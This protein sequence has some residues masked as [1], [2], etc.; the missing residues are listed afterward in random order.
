VKKSL[1][2]LSSAAV[3]GVYGAGYVRTRAAAEHF[4]DEPVRRHPVAPAPAVHGQVAT[5]A[6]AEQPAN[7]VPAAAPAAAAAAMPAPPVSSTTQPSQ[8][9]VAVSPKSVSAPAVQSTATSTPPAAQ[10]DA[11]APAA[12]THAPVAAA[13]QVAALTAD[14]ALSGLP[15]AALPS[16]TLAAPAA[17]QY[18]D[19]T[20]TGW[21]TCRHGDI[22]AKVVIAG[23]KIASATIAQCLTRYSCSWISPLPP[24]VVQRQSA[25]TDYVSGATQSTNAF[26]YAVIE[27]LALA[28]KK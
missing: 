28:K 18:V 1:I 6:A 26:Y 3:L 19:G 4:S 12:V 16:A 11:V 24:Q 13:P 7:A 23:G 2:A 21:G 27:A 17:S 9:N 8:K 15:T 22:Q 14:A 25:E 20:Y 10:A 5:P